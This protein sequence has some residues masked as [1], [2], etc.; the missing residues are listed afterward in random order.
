MDGESIIRPMEIHCNS[1][2]ASDIINSFS[3]LSRKA[4]AYAYVQDSEG[5][6]YKKYIGKAAEI[7]K[8]MSQMR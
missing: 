3:K 8:N 6:H 7:A 4:K 5:N 2:S 1:Y